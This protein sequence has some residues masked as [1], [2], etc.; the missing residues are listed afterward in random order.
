MIDGSVKDAGFTGPDAD[1]Y[2]TA[3]KG[4]RHVIGKEFNVLVPSDL[5]NLEAA[6]SQVAEG[7]MVSAFLKM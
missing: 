6:K 2:A 3:L 5:Q 7:K 4:R 1:K